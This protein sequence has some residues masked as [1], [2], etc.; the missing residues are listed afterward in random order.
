[1]IKLYNAQTDE[2]LGEITDDQFD[3]MQA[4]LEEEAAEDQDYYLNQA[5]IDLLAERGAD[6]ALVAVLTQALGER[7]DLDLRW[8]EA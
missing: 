6:P 1:M 8:E 3:F 4:Q 2:Y 5:T 7:D